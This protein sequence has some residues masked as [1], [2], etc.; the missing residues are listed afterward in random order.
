MAE[1]SQVICGPMK[2]NSSK[3][4]LTAIEKRAEFAK[5]VKLHQTTTQKVLRDVLRISY[6]HYRCILEGTRKPSKAVAERVCRFVDKHPVE[7]W[8]TDEFHEV[9]QST[10]TRLNDA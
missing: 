7:F 9:S 6:S 5:A 10:N 3:S 4:G 8:G 1:F 2:K